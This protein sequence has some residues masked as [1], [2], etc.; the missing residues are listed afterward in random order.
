MNELNSGIIQN[1]SEYSDRLTVVIRKI[2][3]SLQ[4]QDILNNTVEVVRQILEGE[5]VV[6]YSLQEKS[7]G[8]IIAESVI[9]DF[10]QTLGSKI[11]DPCFEYRYINQYQKGRVRAINNIYESGMTSCYME[12]LEKIG[13]KA[14]LVLPLILPDNSLYGL[15]VIHQCSTTRNWQESEI[16]FTMQIVTQVG[17]ALEDAFLLAKYNQLQ[18]QLD[19]SRQW[20][21][22]LL[23]TTHKIYGNNTSLGVLQ[24]VVEQVKGTLSCDRVV[25]YSLQN[26]DQGKIVAEASLPALAS[27]K[28]T[29]IKD[30]CF[31][32][33]YIDKYR[34]GRVKA[35]NNIYESGM[36][37]CY[38]KNLEKIA[39]KANLVVPILNDEEHIFGLLV[40]HQCFEFR[41]WQPEEIEWLQKVALQ[42]GLAFAQ[43]QLKEQ[44]VFMKS[45]FAKIKI[46]QQGI[47]RVNNKIKRIREPIQNMTQNS[48]EINNLTKLLN[49]ETNVLNEANLGQETK[50]IQIIAKKL[51]FATDKFKGL[52][53][54]FQLNFN[55]MENLLENASHPVTLDQQENHQSKSNKI[56]SNNL[57]KPEVEILDLQ[58]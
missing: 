35:I 27:I 26:Q 53:D 31:E 37:P 7:R 54:S 4:E 47:E 45:N 36:T 10:P 28:G 49:R 16:N 40:A 23:E 44:I 34:K 21:Q 32:Y 56:R 55:E 1:I 29:I 5:R 12:N 19:N 14:N 20:Q 30:P 39:V 2:R 24:T 3:I 51:L 17:F 50:L 57:I 52:I 43:A 38:V 33:L 42:T 11:E 25:V 9:A 48:A 58:E 6:I 41:D 22:L 8:T 46:A 15:L 18:T 13:V